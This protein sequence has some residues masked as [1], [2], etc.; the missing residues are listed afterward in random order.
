MTRCE[1]CGKDASGV[2]PRCYRFVCSECVDPITLECV[3][4][5]SF[6]RVLEED[7]LRHLETIEKNVE[8]MESKLEECLH[9]PLYKDS[10]MRSL[11]RVKELE[12][13]AKLESFEKLSEKILDIKDRI[14]RLAINYLIRIKMG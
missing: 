7:L 3:D 10:V 4:C 2:C 13:Y 9:C 5:S 1:L 8:Y 14:Q 12:S 11:R 6:K